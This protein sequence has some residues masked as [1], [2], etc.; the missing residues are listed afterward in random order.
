MSRP[1]SSVLL[2][3]KGPE[4]GPTLELLPAA[5]EA[6]WPVLGP[7]DAAAVSAA[8]GLSRECVLPLPVWPYAR[9]QPW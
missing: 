4:Q 2:A 9:R 8:P 6:G 7:G 3:P 5:A 1:T